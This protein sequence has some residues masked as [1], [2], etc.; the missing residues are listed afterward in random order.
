M[1]SCTL[2][3]DRLCFLSDWL[4]PAFTLSG[5]LMTTIEEARLVKGNQQPRGSGNDR[6]AGGQKTR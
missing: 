5:S 1:R 3:T 4:R 2:R 6:C